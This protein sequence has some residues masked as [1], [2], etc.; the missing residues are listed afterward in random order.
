[1]QLRACIAILLLGVGACAQLP[2]SVRIDVDGKT[3]EVR[4]RGLSS[5]LGGAWSHSRGCEAGHAAEPLGLAGSGS[6]IR[7]VGPDEL[8]VLGSD[9]SVI[10][11]Y[12]CSQ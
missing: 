8:E 12:R 7:L 2:S 4:Q 3:L 5:V 11:L 10:R 1:M 6:T 9:G